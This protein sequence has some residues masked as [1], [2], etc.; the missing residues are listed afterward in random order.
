MKNLKKSQIVK[1][2]KENGGFSAFFN[3]VSKEW[4]TGMNH[5]FSVGLTRGISLKK[6]LNRV[7][8]RLCDGVGA[9]IDPQTEKLVI[10][11]ILHVFSHDDARLIGKAFRQDCYYDFKTGQC[12]D[13]DYTGHTLHNDLDGIR[14]YISISGLSGFSDIYLKRAAFF[15]SAAHSWI[16]DLVSFYDGRYTLEQIAGCVAALSPLMRWDKNKACAEALLQAHSLD[17]DIWS[18]LQNFPVFRANARKAIQILDLKNPS[19]EDV[20]KVLNGVKI[21]NFFKNLLGNQYNV[22]IDTWMLRYMLHLP[23]NAQ[24]SGLFTHENINELTKQINDATN[25]LPRDIRSF[26]R[27]FFSQSVLKPCEIQAI[28]WEV[29]RLIAG[30]GEIDNA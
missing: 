12:Y 15:Y 21:T 30:K 27:A 11:P 18:R 24:V 16:N 29:A 23:M 10:D 13:L 1:A 9:W 4:R 6:A 5:G 19:K 8:S 20:E 26:N 7:D 22:T 3:H 14:R 2:C 25:F 28:I 17:G